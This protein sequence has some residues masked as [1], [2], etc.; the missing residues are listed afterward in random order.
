MFF[1]RETAFQL[2]R[3]PSDALALNIFM[4]LLLIILLAAANFRWI[5]MPLRQRGKLIADKLINDHSPH[6]S[7]TN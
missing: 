5:E 3:K 4:A 2:E 1:L 6:E 7:I